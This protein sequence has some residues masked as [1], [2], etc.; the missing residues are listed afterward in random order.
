[1]YNSLFIFAQIKKMEKEKKSTGKHWVI[2]LLSTVAFFVTYIYAGGYCS[3]VL[4]FVVT[5]FAMALDL[6]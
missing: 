1:M 5:S 3:M 2:F 6:L 4:P